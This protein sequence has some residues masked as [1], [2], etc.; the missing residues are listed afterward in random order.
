MMP[1][2]SAL[3]P[4]IDELSSA[5]CVQHELTSLESRLGLHGTATWGVG[6]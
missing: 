5:L 4:E 3:L 1:M 6:R 2:V